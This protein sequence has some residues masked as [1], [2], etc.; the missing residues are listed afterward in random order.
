[1]KERLYNSIR[2]NDSGFIRDMK[3]NSIVILECE[4]LGV[5]I[6]QLLSEHASYTWVLISVPD[7]LI[8][9]R[10]PYTLPTVM[11]YWIQQTTQ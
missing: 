10:Q 3:L 4:V 7:C 8:A 9:R 2:I 5:E 1:M 6:H 11:M